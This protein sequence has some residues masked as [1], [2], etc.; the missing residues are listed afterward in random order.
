MTVTL[1]SVSKSYQTPAGRCQVLR[2]VSAV[3]QPGLSVG[4]L[5]ARRSGKSTL[6]QILTGAIHPDVGYVSHRSLVSFP[7]CSGVI[8]PAMTIRQNI[9]FLA[10]LY[11]LDPKPIIQFV[12]EF[13]S[14]GELLDQRLKACSKDQ[15][16]KLL[17]TISYAIPFDIY[18]CDE[19]I[20]GGP[21]PFRSSCEGLVQERRR[22]SGLVFTTKSPLLMRK[23]ADI[24]AVLIGGRLVFFP[25]VEEAIVAFGDCADVSE[26]LLDTPDLREEEP[27]YSTDII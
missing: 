23:F 19:S 21:E 10:R 12:A 27:D 11:N 7:A 13:A 22:N 5:G 14:L 15:R 16:S 25:S 3:F 8:H 20:V 4:I 24:G 6:I 17:F 9:A 2:D 1:N 18:L 26:V